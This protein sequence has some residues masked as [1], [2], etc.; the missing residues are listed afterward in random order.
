MNRRQLS[1]AQEVGRAQ[2]AKGIVER[3]RTAL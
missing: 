1:A 3:Q 2:V